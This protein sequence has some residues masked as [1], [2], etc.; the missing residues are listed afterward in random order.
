MA[1]VDK[2]FAREI[3]EKEIKTWVSKGGKA[4]FIAHQMALNP[5]S[6]STPVRCCF[7]S[8]QRYKGCS[9]NTSWELGPDLVNSPLAEGY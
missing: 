2:K 5:Q 9:L 6:K 8:S 7:N 4:Y 1:L 3:S